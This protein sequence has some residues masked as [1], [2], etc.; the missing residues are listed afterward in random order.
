M[1][2]LKPYRPVDPHPDR[3]VICTRCG[4]RA[5]QYRGMWPNPHE[6]PNGMPAGTICDHHAYTCLHCGPDEHGGWQISY[7]KSNDEP[8]RIVVDGG[9][10]EL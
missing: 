4:N 1:S 2:N 7:A 8:D 5:E 6:H 3:P 9:V 10:I